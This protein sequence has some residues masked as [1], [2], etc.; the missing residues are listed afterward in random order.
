MPFASQRMRVCILHPSHSLHGRPGMSD[1]DPDY[2]ILQKYYSPRAARRAGR[3]APPSMPCVRSVRS[4]RSVVGCRRCPVRGPRPRCFTDAPHSGRARMRAVPVPDISPVPVPDDKKAR[5]CPGC[6]RHR[7]RAGGGRARMICPFP[8]D[9]RVRMIYPCCVT[10]VTSYTPVCRH[11]TDTREGSDDKRARLG[12]SSRPP[13]GS[14][15]TDRA[16]TR[17]TTPAESLVV[18]EKQGR[19]RGKS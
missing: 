7:H 1:Y 4:A 17:C 2:Y 11:D 6:H 18:R 19:S 5:I 12:R 10:D 16:F 14:V 9:K 8:D 15:G 3:R 13:P